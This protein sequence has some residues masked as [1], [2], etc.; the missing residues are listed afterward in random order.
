MT[1]PGAT[2]TVGAMQPDVVHGATDGDLARAVAASP[3]GG[4]EPAEAE[5]YR[6]FAPRVRLYGRRHLRDDAAAQ[7]LAHEVLVTAIERLRAGRVRDP[8]QIGS[9]ILSTARLSAATNRRTEQRRGQLGARVEI[10][11]TVDPSFEDAVDLPRVARCLDALDAQA[12]EVLI[13][14]YYADRT[15][16]EIAAELGRTSGAVRVARHRAMEQLRACMG[17]RREA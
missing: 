4:A 10:P 2:S 15:A 13:L 8:E 6:R 5:L 1:T 3:D 7:D 16:A 11:Q 12:R 9:F 14:T 17:L